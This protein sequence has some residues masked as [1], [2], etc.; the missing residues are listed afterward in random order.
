MSLLSTWHW[1]STIF[2]LCLGPRTLSWEPAQHKALCIPQLFCQC[3][4][5][6]LGKQTESK[7]QTVPQLGV[8]CT[9]WCGGEGKQVKWA[10]QW[11]GLGAG[12]GGPLQHGESRWPQTQSQRDSGPG[13]SNEWPGS[14]EGPKERR[15]INTMDL[16]VTFVRGPA[17]SRHPAETKPHCIRKACQQA[18]RPQLSSPF[19]NLFNSFFPDSAF[20]S[21]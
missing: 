14:E 17:I 19:S 15:Y 5:C 21:I 3:S 7:R 16:R 8:V 10:G 11:T 18:R 1:H 9:R 6:F 4:N 2:P 12:R 13:T 20:Y